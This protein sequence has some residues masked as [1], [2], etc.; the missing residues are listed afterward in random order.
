MCHTRSSRGKLHNFLLLASAF[1]CMLVR[2][3]IPPLPKAARFHHDSQE[4]KVSL[5]LVSG[6]SRILF[7]FLTNQFLF[8]FFHHYSERKKEIF[9]Y[10]HMR[11]SLWGSIS[12]TAGQKKFLFSSRRRS[13]TLKTTLMMLLKLNPVSHRTS[14]TFISATYKTI[15]VESAIEL[16]MRVLQSS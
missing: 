2:K 4:T 16:Q 15:Q 13:R 9:T 6:V 11:H 14:E 10:M 8:S 5:V 7:S 12:A 1:N 3:A